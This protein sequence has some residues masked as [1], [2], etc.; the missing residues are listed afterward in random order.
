MAFVTSTI[1]QVVRHQDLPTL[2]HFYAK[3][4]DACHE[5]DVNLSKIT[6]IIGMDPALSHKVMVLASNA[7][8]RE[9][10]IVDNIEQAVNIIGPDM[11]RAIVSHALTRQVFYAAGTDSIKD[12]T[13]F[14]R[15][16]IA[17]AHAGELIAREITYSDP[18][19]AFLSGLLHDVG[20]LVL[21]TRYPNKFENLLCPDDARPEHRL[22]EEK[23]LGFDH[24]KAGARL[25][26]SWGQQTFIADAILYHHHP[27]ESIKN[28]FPLVQIVYTANI[29]ATF[30]KE[31]RERGR[32]VA[33]ELFGFVAHQVDEI[34]QHMESQTQE[35][36]RLMGLDD[37]GPGDHH[38]FIDDYSGVQNK[39]QNE[40]CTASFLS[41]VMQNLLEAANRHE[42]IQEIKQTVWVMFDVDDIMLFLYEPREEML[43]GQADDRGADDVMRIPM[44]VKDCLPVSSLFQKEIVDSFTRSSYS[45]PTI[46]DAQLISRL[47]KNGM[48]CVPLLAKETMIGCMLLGVDKAAFPFLSKQFNLLNLIAHK[49]AAA[50]YVERE[51]SVE[52][53]S[54][55]SRHEEAT[56]IKTRKIVHEVNN[57]LGV[58]KNYL[59]VLELKLSEQDVVCDEIR[60]I[61]EEISRVG[62]ILKGLTSKAEAE[63]PDIPQID[64]NMALSDMARL[65][66]ATLKSR[67]EIQIH[68]NLD[69]DLP[70]AGVDK[71][72]VKQIA[73]NLLKNAAEALPDGGS[74]YL[75]TSQIPG[76]PS[77]GTQKENSPGKARI[78]IRDNGPGLSGMVRSKLFEPHV[79]SKPDHEGLG[80]SVVKNLIHKL[81]GSI[82]CESSHE[83]TCFTIELPI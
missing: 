81:N 3:L 60:I 5:G 34:C 63:D 32:D 28:A 40:V 48:L 14:W 56:S 66:G 18:G 19:K 27:L 83:G 69:D 13:F 41:N 39:I 9:P 47:G 53:K 10:S 52:F 72:S 12:L 37:P 46:I 24:A 61:S 23:E 62:V 8:K 49:S 42:I 76:G 29:L 36:V 6:G 21:L 55:L 70:K 25:I 7:K 11:I 78:L 44:K 1:S 77:N 31:N 15:H 82:A 58:I 2:P 71:D 16:A 50:L 65:M 79:T 59:K 33:R 45:K 30:H 22:E 80:L 64:L 73:L 43:I 68:L 54:K 35:S 17:C 74:I 20:K 51:R 4:I 57:P 75:Q 67:G 38:T 26:Q